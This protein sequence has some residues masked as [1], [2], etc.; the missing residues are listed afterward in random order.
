MKIPLFKNFRNAKLF[1]SWRRFYR[2]TKRQYYTEKLKKSFFFVDKHLLNGIL[3]ARSAL[4]P[5]NV[6]NIFDMKLTTSVLLNKFNELHKYNLMTTEKK[7]NQFRTIVK[8]IITTA[9]NNSYQEYTY[10]TSTIYIVYYILVN[11]S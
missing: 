1:D 3:E 6:Y 9:C 11:Y 8:N 10:P 5:M 4:K 7:I 2:K